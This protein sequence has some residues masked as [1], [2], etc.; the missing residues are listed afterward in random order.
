[1]VLECVLDLFWMCIGY[2]L[3]VSGKLFDR[4]LI[5]LGYF[6]ICLDMFEYFLDMLW[7]CSGSVLDI[8][9]Y[10]LDVFWICLGSL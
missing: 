5:I 3:D 10:I 4:F 6:W 1:M 9:C 7:R 2:F 8:S